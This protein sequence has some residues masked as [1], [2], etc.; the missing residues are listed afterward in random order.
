MYSE[1]WNIIKN[2][3]IGTLESIEDKNIFSGYIFQYD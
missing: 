2:F 1:A 3:F